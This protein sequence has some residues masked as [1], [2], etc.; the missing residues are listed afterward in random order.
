MVGSQVYDDAEA[1]RAIFV[2]EFNA[3][4]SEENAIM[5]S[6]EDNEVAI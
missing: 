3:K 5:K 2:E 1:L 4:F 6:E